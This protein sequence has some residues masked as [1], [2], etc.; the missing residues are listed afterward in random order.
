[1]AKSF[2]KLCLIEQESI[3]S[4]YLTANGRAIKPIQSPCSHRIESS[5]LVCSTIDL[6]LYDGNVE[7][8]YILHMGMLNLNWTFKL[9]ILFGYFIDYFIELF[10]NYEPIFAISYFKNDPANIYLF[11]V[12]NRNARNR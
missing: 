1:M 3:I 8:K 9:I 4:K 2:A 12:N 6:F 7:L 5:Q 10:W 11:K